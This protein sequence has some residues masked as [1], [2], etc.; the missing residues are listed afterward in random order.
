T[1]NHVENGMPENDSRPLPAPIVQPGRV[2]HSPVPSL[3]TANRPKRNGVG[4]RFRATI[5]H[6][7]NG[8][9]E[10]DSRPLPHS[11]QRS[12]FLAT[13]RGWPGYCW[14]WG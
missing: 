8:M 11:Y 12:C 10:N 7:E 14:P 4:S 5:N 13:V 9:P 3:S 6:V 2:Q 1:I